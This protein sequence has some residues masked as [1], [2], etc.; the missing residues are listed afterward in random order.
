[1]TRRLLLVEDNATDEK[2]AV[3][4]FKRC[5][6]TSELVIVR[7]GA[8]ALDYLFATGAHEGRDAHDTPALVLLDLRLPRIG[9]LDVLARLRADDRTRMVPVVILSTSN[10]PDDVARGYALGANAY[11][12]K[13]IDFDQFVDAARALDT[14]WLRLNEPPPRPDA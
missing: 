2:L 5:G 9:G 7:D 6:M 13:P 10:E 12:R 4:A 3:R 8:E 11:L 1:M 14:F